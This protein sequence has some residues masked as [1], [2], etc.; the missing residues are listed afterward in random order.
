MTAACT[1]AAGIRVRHAR[2]TEGQK[3]TL[4]RLSSL[5]VLPQLPD[6]PCLAFARPAPLVMEIGAGTGDVSVDLARRH[7]ENNY[8]VVEVYPGGVAQLLRQCERY[9]LDNV[10]VVMHD[11]AAVLARLPEHSID[12]IMI[13]FP[14]PWP[15]KRHHKRRLLQSPFLSNVAAKLV[16]SG[17]VYVTTDDAGYAE[18]IEHAVSMSSLVKLDSGPARLRP[19][20]RQFT[21]YERKAMLK[22]N[23]V[24]EWLLSQSSKP[25]GAAGDDGA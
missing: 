4:R 6:D 20:W 1:G 10:R 22:G 3:K 15:K 2:L 23:V 5:W 24:H 11:A 8:L 7:P 12:K 17:R 21:R 13:F 25:T 14:D 18:H 9:H 19:R 16:P